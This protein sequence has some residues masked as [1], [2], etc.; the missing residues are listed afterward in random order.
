MQVV[1]FDLIYIRKQKFQI[2][3]HLKLILKIFN[4]YHRIISILHLFLQH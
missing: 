2:Q 4:D 3:K 1:Y